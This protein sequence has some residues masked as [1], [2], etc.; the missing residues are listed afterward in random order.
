MEDVFE[1]RNQ[2][3][4]D[5]TPHRIAEKSATLDLTQLSVALPPPNRTPAL[6]PVMFAEMVPASRLILRRRFLL[7]PHRDRLLQSSPG[8]RS[9][10]PRFHHELKSRCSRRARKMRDAVAHSARAQN[11]ELPICMTT[12]SFHKTDYLTPTSTKNPEVYKPPKCRYYPC[13]VPPGE[14]T[15]ML[16]GPAAKKLRCFL[17]LK[18]SFTS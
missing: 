7:R 12:P 13:S 5:G 14:K 10:K 3:T 17:T 16:P 18:S 9:T 6:R 4:S 15:R 11:S 2:N 1:A 8:A